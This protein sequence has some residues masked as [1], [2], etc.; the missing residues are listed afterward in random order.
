MCILKRKS[1][2]SQSL[3][4]GENRG[5]YF[6]ELACVVVKVGKAKL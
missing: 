2:Y 1:D 6:K 5:R 3:G 4:E